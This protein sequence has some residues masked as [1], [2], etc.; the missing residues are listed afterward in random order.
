MKKIF[1]IALTLASMICLTVPASAL[2]AGD[3]IYLVSSG[4]DPES[5]TAHF[6]DGNNG[7]YQAIPMSRLENDGGFTVTIPDAMERVYFEA[8]NPESLAGNG[9]P[10]KLAQVTGNIFDIATDTWSASGSS[11]EEDTTVSLSSGDGSTAETGEISETINVK[12]LIGESTPSAE[13]VS[14]D[15][16]WGNMEFTYTPPSQGTWDPGSHT[17]TDGETAGSWTSSSNSIEVTNHS[18]VDVTASFGFESAD[19]LDID[20]EFQDTAGDVVESLVLASADNGQAGQAGTPTT[21]T[22]YFYV[23]GGAIASA[24][25]SL[26]TISVTVSKR[27]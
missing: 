26:G 17:Y 4:A 1:M 15:I 19:E 2:N 22:V 8:S 21:K 20:G 23:T 6:M 12:G 18:N 3:T 27:Q 24:T 25:D 9:V 10:H 5:V 14:V 16:I 7:N 11:A 13:V